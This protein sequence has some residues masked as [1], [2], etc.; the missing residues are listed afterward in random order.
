MDIERSMEFIVKNLAAV[1]AAQQQA[2][3]RMARMER[4]TRGLQTLMKIGMRRLVK[5]EQV[6]A[7]QQKR[8]DARFAEVA[9]DI[10]QL[11][12]AQKRTDLRFDRWLDSHKGGNGKRSNS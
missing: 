6:L 3:V 4:Q 8:T 5:I 2:E 7:A 11:T 1:A 12:A 9:T 10:K